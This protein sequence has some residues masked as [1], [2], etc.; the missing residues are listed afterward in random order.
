VNDALM[1]LFFFVVGLEIKRE[2]T[3]GE[4]APRERAMLPVFGALGGMIAPAL[5]YLWLQPG[6]EA[7]V[8]RGIPMATDIAFAVAALALSGPRVPPGLKVFLLALAIVDDLGA[9][10]VDRGLLHRRDPPLGALRGV[11]RAR[12]HPRHPARQRARLCALHWTR[13]R[14][15]P[16]EWY[17]AYLRTTLERDIPQLGF[18]IATSRLRRCEARSCR[19][20]SSSAS[21]CPTCAG[22]R[23]VCTTWGSR[24]ATS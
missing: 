20:R 22:S 19:S 24:G 15:E 12:P 21:A 8:G 4:L 6:A 9:V 23:P 10:T 14:A 16:G 5:L 1:A 18:R 7:R 11:A 17:P 13:P 2:L 3:I